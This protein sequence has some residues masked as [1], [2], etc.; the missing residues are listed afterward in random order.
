[1]KETV[2]VSIASQAFTLDVDA[3]QMLSSYLDNIRDR[4]EPDDAEAVVDIESRIAD[5]FSESLSS[6]IMVVTASLV[7]RVM[8]QIGSPE[9]FGAPHRGTDGGEGCAAESATDVSS[10]PLRRSRDERV[11]AG[12]CGGIAVRFGWDPAVVR[13][14][15]A[16]LMIFMGLSVWVY[17]IMWLVI[18]AESKN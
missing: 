12:V 3:W 9:I 18:P 5:I 15:T 13:L 11:L 2:N 7:R 4:L 6:P 17:V 16:L 8:E 1:M 10:A 14:V